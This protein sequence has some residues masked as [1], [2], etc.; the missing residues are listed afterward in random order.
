VLP[1]KI[2]WPTDFFDADLP[3]L[4]MAADLARAGGGELLL[5]HVVGDPAEELYGEKSKEGKDRA[6]WGLWRV[7][8][9]KIETRLRELAATHVKDLQR[10]RVICAFG[11]PATRI[12][13]TVREEQV[14]AL[15]IAARR[16]RSLLGEMLLGSLAYKVVRTAPC[17]VVVVK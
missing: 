10:T 17:H 11:D 15:V 16:D 1:K 14:D 5:L 4:G 8:K 3:A 12:L 2:L 13:E 6:A 9:E 7:A